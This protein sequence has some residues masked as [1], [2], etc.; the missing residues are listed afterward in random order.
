MTEKQILLHIG[1]HKTGTTSLQHALGNNRATLIEQG[2]D[3]YLGAAKP[4]NHVEIYLA[5]LRRNVETLGRKTH[6]RRP[7]FTRRAVRKRVRAFIA[8]STCDRIIFSCE[9]ISLLRTKRELRALHDL[10]GHQHRIRVFLTLREK[11]AFLASYRAQILKG[12]RREPSR[13]PKSALYVEPDSWLVDYDALTTAFESE[14]GPLALFDYG[15]GIV[16]DI[17]RAMGLVLP[18]SALGTELNTTQ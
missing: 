1:T 2:F 14:F 8:Q 16:P 4:F 7:E 3:Y 5:T 15:P 6:G 9:G 17:I 10:F 12:R 13:N 18:D 11:S